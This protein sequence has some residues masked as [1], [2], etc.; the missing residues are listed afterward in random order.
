MKWCE[1][2]KDKIILNFDNVV[3]F[4]KGETKIIVYTTMQGL[5]ID[6]NYDKSIIDKAYE[7][8]K[9]MLVENKNKLGDLTLREIK[10]KYLNQ[11]Q[12]CEHCKHD[13]AT[14][15][16]LCEIANLIDSLYDDKDLEYEGYSNS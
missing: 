4:E 15:C 8:L 10:R 6:L 3:A 16:N 14:C 12:D 5:T 9:E 11:E 13:T 2:T 1:I 7:E